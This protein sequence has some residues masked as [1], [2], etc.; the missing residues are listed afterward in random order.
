MYQPESLRTDEYLPWSRG[1]GNDV[2]AMLRAAADGDLA[3]LQTLLAREPSL[4]DCEFQYYR[5]LLFA[6]LNN[7]LGAV[8]LSSMRGRPP[9]AVWTQPMA[10]AELFGHA[11][12]ADV[13]R[14][15]LS[16]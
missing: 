12:V 7:R 4:I 9:C 16:P 1:R 14:K 6:E 15:A 5:P 2:W 10:W 8:R 11:A 13:L 3:T